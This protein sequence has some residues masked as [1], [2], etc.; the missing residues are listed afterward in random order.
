M[1]ALPRQRP[2]PLPA[3]H[4]LPE[5]LAT[6]QRAAW[7][8][9]MKQALQVPWMGVVTMAF[10]HYPTF[11]GELWRGLKP[12]SESTAFVDA[13][14]ALRTEVE[15]RVAGLAPQNLCDAL[16]R[17]GYAPREIDTLRDVNTVFSHGNPP[18]LLIATL[19]R[20]LLELGDL[21]GPHTADAFTG[22]HAPEVA[23]PLVLMEA[24]HA[25]AP[26]QAIYA[27]IKATLDLP[28]VNTDYRAFARWPSYFALAWNDLRCTVGTPAHE[29]IC[30][31]CHD[32]A[33]ARVAALPNPG[34][35][36]ATALRQAAEADAPIDE[37]MRVCQLFQWLLPGLM[38]NVACF[39][40]QLQAH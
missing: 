7:Y 1:F 19:A 21:T 17:H 6:S 12:L 23:V 8:A 16:A 31:A 39:R 28:F 10:A 14:R 36:S 9:D 15:Q 3:I 30:Q 22:R 20:H 33:A 35:L 38:V 34:K 2:D 5:Y 37:V 11:F 26:T 24:H 29:A 25:D 18:Y 13:S 40:Q 4:P 32:Q 27:D